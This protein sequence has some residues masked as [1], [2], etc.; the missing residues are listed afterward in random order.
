[1]VSLIQETIAAGA[2]QKCTCEIVGIHC[3]TYQR[4][5]KNDEI[6]ADKRLN[7][8]PACHNALTDEDKKAMIDIT[9]QPEY[10]H[11]TPHHIVPML[12]DKG[13]YIGSESSFY[14]AMRE[15]NQLKHRAKSTPKKRKKPAPL[16][17]TKPP[18]C[19]H[20]CRLKK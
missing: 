11:L 15:H 6:Q 4:W 2:R 5:M 14:R 3:R 13:Q 8:I 19:H 9:N 10:S 7:N 1:M 12:L 16:V 17:A 20:T 18:L